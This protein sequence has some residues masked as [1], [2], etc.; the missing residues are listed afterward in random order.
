MAITILNSNERHRLERL[1]N[2]RS[3]WTDGG[4]W[5]GPGK[6]PDCYKTQISRN[7]LTKII[8]FDSDESA[9][10]W[11]AECDKQIRVV[12]H[13]GS[14]G[15]NVA[16]A[17]IPFGA[18]AKLSGELA[19]L[20]VSVVAAT[21]AGIVHGELVARIP[22]PEVGK[23]WKVQIDFEHEIR[24]KPV[25]SGRNTFKQKLT[26]ASYDQEGKARYQ[27]STVNEFR[28]ADL[29]SG[30]AEKLVSIPNRKLMNSYQ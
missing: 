24:W 19:K 14:A 30:L 4:H 16:L 15:L 2:T 20:W 29:P 5:M 1:C 26:I 8:T 22:Y 10:K 11:N 18:I 17:F 27:A 13:M 12:G 25:I 6:V 3:N 28:L 21:T 7:R 9:F 23:G